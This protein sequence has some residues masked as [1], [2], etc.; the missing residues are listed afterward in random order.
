MLCPLFQPERYFL[1]VPS[2]RS[3][4]N[5]LALLLLSEELAPSLPSPSTSS[6]SLS[7]S[8]TTSPPF[9]RNGPF[10]LLGHLFPAATAAAFL[11]LFRELSSA[12]MRVEQG[13]ACIKCPS[14]KPPWRPLRPLLPL[15]PWL[16]RARAKTS[17]E[18]WRRGKRQSLSF[19]SSVH[20]LHVR[21]SFRKGGLAL[22][23]V[24]ARSAVFGRRLLRT[25]KKV[26]RA[27]ALVVA[28]ASANAASFLLHEEKAESNATAAAAAASS[29]ATVSFSRGSGG[30][31]SVSPS[32]RANSSTRSTATYTIHHHTTVVLK[33][34]K[35]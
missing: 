31:S 7:S 11:R 33:R 6:L 4:Q 5:C 21:P 22:D 20:P 16:H 23:V 28:L 24:F 30:V 17:E 10:P 15:T 8:W 14:R 34:M 29:S 12:K 13:N 26:A 32:E 35:L 18:G 25:Q 1:W 3:S 9:Y 27:F 19:S 2:K